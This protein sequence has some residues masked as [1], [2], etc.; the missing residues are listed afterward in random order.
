M[1]MFDH[2]NQAKGFEQAF[3]NDVPPDDHGAS[4]TAEDRAILRKA[5]TSHADWPAYRSA[6]QIDASSLD[7]RRCLHAC[8]ALKIDWRVL[9]MEQAGKT[10]DEVKPAPVPRTTVAPPP[11]APQPAPKPAEKAPELRSSDFPKE[12]APLPE[13]APVPPPTFTGDAIS[14]ALANVLWPPML[15]AV[16]SE[17]HHA[18]EAKIGTLP[19]V[20]IEVANA[21]AVRP[22][23][24]THHPMLPKLIRW[25]SIR[26]RDGFPPNVW[27]AGPAGSG[28]SH[29]A[30]QA[31]ESFGQEF[32]AQG[33][34]SQGFELIGFLDAA[35]NYHTTPFRE[36]YEHG[37]LCLLDEID[38]GDNSAILTINGATANGSYRFPDGKLVKRHPEFRLIGAANTWGHGATAEYVGRA[39][40]DTAILS[41]FPTKLA[42][43]Y[44]TGFEMQIAGADDPKCQAWVRRVQAARE[45]VRQRGLK[46][47]IDPRHSITGA[48]AIAA[49]FSPDEVAADTYLAGL[50]PDVIAQVEGKY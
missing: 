3:T 22:V 34:M 44:D 10:A 39:K 24:A 12:R 47:L 5:I 18:I 46:I 2:S 43:D 29:A 31:A 8:A 25:L 36:A 30:K 4:I 6:W 49:G 26:Q 9:L 13:R 14:T 32:Y 27:I 48:A 40:I 16:Q 38:S 37:G 11:P 19:T 35:G 45:R 23:P 28:K 1:D 15:A 7:R 42:W 50:K 21:G 41:R 17:M 33:A 20:R